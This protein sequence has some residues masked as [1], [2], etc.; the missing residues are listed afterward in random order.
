PPTAAP[1]AADAT[2]Q[3]AATPTAPPR[4]PPPRG[5]ALVRGGA[6]LFSK[7]D[8]SAKI[9]ALPIAKATAPSDPALAPVPPTGTVVVVVGAH[10]DFIAVETLVDANQ[11]CAS[12]LATWS[13]LRVGLF[14]RR[15]DLLRVTTKKVEHTFA[16]GTSVAVDAGAPIGDT[17]S[18]AGEHVV[19]AGG[20][21]L[22]LPLPADAIGVFYEPTRR[23]WD[24][25]A[26][27]VRGDA[28][29]YGGGRPLGPA[30]ALDR[31]GNGVIARERKPAE[32]GR[33]LVRVGSRCATVWAL[34]D[35]TAIEPF[36]LHSGLYAMKGGTSAGILGLIGSA[37]GGGLELEIRAGAALTWPDGRPAGV[38]ERAIT[39]THAPRID[40]ARS[41]LAVPF[42]LDDAT[43]PELCVATADV[44]AIETAD[45]DP[46][47]GLT[48]EEIGEPFGVGGLGLSGGGDLGSGGFGGGGLGRTAAKSKVKPGTAGV[49]G[50]L[51]KDIIRRIVRAHLG[52]IRACYETQLSTSPTLAGKVVVS[53]VIDP[54]G[55]VKSSSLKESTMGNADVDRCVLKAV[56]A[57]AFPKPVGGGVV[58]V[59]YPFVFS[60]G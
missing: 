6:D 48:G 36:E 19:D 9:G 5:F 44:S 20:V 18:G 30:A 46:W 24:S 15:A 10:D 43:G 47:G 56:K 31:D 51:D 13:D 39:S 2:T 54:D 58:A 1:T 52:K 53:F 21:A 4:E 59:T 25:G 40:G 17:P 29:A 8:A 37:G 14:V 23:P 38:A 11:H 50:S 60:S 28:L 49:H 27:R 34:A 3:P 42:A 7:P 33:A 55:A 32:D 12:G 57:M 41:C 35:A 22:E 26:D 16:D 45:A